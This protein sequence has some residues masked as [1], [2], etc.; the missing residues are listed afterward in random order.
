MANASKGRAG[1]QKGAAAWLR[2]GDRRYRTLIEH[3]SDVIALVDRDGRIA[4]A[5]PSSKRLLGYE[6]EE[7]EGQSAFDLV[8]AGEAG[9]LRTRFEQALE[10]EGEARA[11]EFQFRHKDGVWRL[12]EGV[13]RRFPGDPPLVLL[14]V[15]DITDHRRAEHAQLETENRYQT[16]FERNPFPM[17]AYDLESL[18]FLAVNDAAVEHYGYSREEFLSMTLRDIRPPDELGRLESDLLAV[19]SGSLDP[20]SWNAA[21]WKHRKKDGTIFDVEIR[22]TTLSFGGW[23]ARLVMAKDVSTERRL[24]DQLRQAQK[25]EAVGRLSAGVAHDFNNLLGIILGYGAILR[26]RLTDETL[27]AKLEQIMKAGEQAAGLTRQL[28]TFSRK[29][30]V[31][32]RVL[33]LNLLVSDLGKMLQRVVGEDI[34]LKIAAGG[35]L[36][37]VR[38]DPGQIEQVLMNLVG[39]ARDAM[40]RGGGLTV[41]TGNVDLD[42][43]YASE[44]AAVR[45]GPYVLLAVSDTGTGMDAETQRH[46]F[47]PFFTTKDPGKGTGLG[48]ATAYGIVTQS[49]GHIAVYSEVGRGTTFKVYLPC[50]DAPAERRTAGGD[51]KLAGGTETIL[52]V[53]DDGGLRELTREVLEERGYRILSAPSGP[54]ALALAEAHA[55]TIHLLLTDV[56]MLGMSGRE[57]AQALAVS[58]PQT[59]VLFTSGYTDDAIVHH[60]VLEEGTAFIQKPFTPGSLLAKVREALEAD[61]S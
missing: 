41:A 40:P 19:R 18:R 36:G 45:P 20:S 59:K 24:E 55:G 16:L 47:E 35:D 58:R 38:A 5:S 2:L 32:P 42:E 21:I 22:S 28:L 54:E 61:R 34:D 57:L 50:V 14:T 17:W 48:L 31:Q 56:V 43:L 52:V 30:V 11:I 39:N 49:G 44:H 37:R 9:G 13:G 4:Y 29:Q 10:L 33:D 1:D 60:R 8:P 27:R 15:R 7:L 3:L 6:Q 23:E 51:Q 12:L 46:I 25:M 53:E 26:S